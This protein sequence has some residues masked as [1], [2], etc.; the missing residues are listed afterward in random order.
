MI[1]NSLTI[2]VII[3]YVNLNLII[4]TFEITKK[5][6]KNYKMSFKY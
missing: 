2:F 3:F 4:E 5:I 6:S 1:Y